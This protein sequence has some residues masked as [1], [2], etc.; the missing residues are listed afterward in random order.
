MKRYKLI[1]DLPTFDAGDTFEL[2]DGGLF[3]EEDSV[4][5]YSHR[6]LAKFP[7]IL[8][9]WFEE[10]KSPLIKDEKIRKAIKAWAEANGI[11]SSSKCLVY[12]LEFCGLFVRCFD[13]YGNCNDI[14][15]RSD[16]PKELDEHAKY[17]I[18]E[19][20]GEPIDEEVI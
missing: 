16:F 10:I 1:K 14:D 3:R 9:D 7:S 4:Y 17:T 19:L 18:E 6:T 5:A 20:V 12:S 13:E 2:K 8:K 11:S 15:F